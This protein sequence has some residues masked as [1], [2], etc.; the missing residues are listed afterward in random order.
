M[1]EQV[2]DGVEV[3]RLRPPFPRLQRLTNVY[4]LEDDGGVTVFESGSLR[5]AR[6]IDL[7]GA[8]RGGIKRIVL[9][10]AHVD[11]RGGAAGIDA[12]IYCHPDER[13]D[14]EGDAGE[15]YFDYSKVRNPLVRALA[16]NTTRQMDG[17]P[18][19]VAGTV[20]EGD[21]LAGFRVLHLPGHAPGQIGLWRQSDRLAIV[22]DTVFVFN[23][24][25]VMALSGGPR[26][27]PAAIRP[28]P[29]AARES[30]R[31]VAALEPAAVW[32]GHYGPIAG[33]VRSQ[34][35]RAAESP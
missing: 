14:V 4:L 22:S 17:G 28:L 29:D 13:A 10:H 35:E 11:H 26:M 9:S 24:F 15:H 1:A 8:E 25:S 2:A 33:D 21:E 20:S 12:P 7:A 23:P 18:L 32:L 5:N 19:K 30:I 27:P 6:A 31:R 3:L 34:L 16:P